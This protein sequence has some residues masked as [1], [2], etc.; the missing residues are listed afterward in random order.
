MTDDHLYARRS[1]V[2]RVGP[3]EIDIMPMLESD[4]DPVLAIEAAS[5]STPWS[6][7]MF[8]NELKHNPY[9]HLFVARERESKSALGGLIGHICFW[10]ILDELHLLNLSVHP[11]FRRQGF[12][13]KL[14]RFVLQSGREKGARKAS[15]EVRAGNK[16]A[17]G[18]YEKIG[19][20]VAAIRPGY[21]REPREDALIMTLE[22]W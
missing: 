7:S 12:G 15:L 4:L 10:V 1:S 18:L 9:S 11:D 19:F 17:I 5:F 20:K 14:A 22:G 13:E 6:R 21:Y 16:P 3:M 8:E 2:D